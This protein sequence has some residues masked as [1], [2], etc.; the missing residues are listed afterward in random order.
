MGGRQFRTFT[1]WILV[2]L[3]VVY[4]VQYLLG[5]KGRENEI[6][7]TEFVEQ[8]DKGNLESVTFVEKELRG[9]LKTKMPANPAEGRGE[10][11][12][13]RVYLPVEL[14]LIHI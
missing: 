10:I 11:E 7:Y 3:A 4:F 2:A 13:F 12:K 8:M 1:V 14:S 5:P 9:E 6:T